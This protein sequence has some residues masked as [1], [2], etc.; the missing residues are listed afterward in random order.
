MDMD[1]RTHKSLQQPKKLITQLP[2]LAHYNPK[3]ENILTTDASTKELGATLWQK[4]KNGNLKPIGFASRFLSDTEKKYAINELELLAVVWGL[5]HFRLYI[6]GKPIELLTNHQALEPLIKRNRSNKT[7]SARLTRWLDR[8][9]HFDIQIKHVA[10]KH[11][12]LTDYL[13]R[14]PISKPEPIE[15]YDEE[16]VFNCIIPLLEFINTIYGSI[17]D[18]IERTARTDQKKSNQTTSQSNSR[19]VQKLQTMTANINTAVRCYHNKI[20]SALTNLKTITAK[21]KKWI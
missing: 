15:N 17:T 14:N 9:A 20:Q 3:S 19:H 10:G 16:Y 4:Q 5:E 18:E 2:C 6:Y 7:Y 11:L 21:A 1:R 12:N 8:L 13:S